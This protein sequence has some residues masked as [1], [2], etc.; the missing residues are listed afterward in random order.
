MSI[1]DGCPFYRFKSSIKEFGDPTSPIVLIGEAPGATEYQEGEVFV[2]QSGQLLRKFLER[3]GLLDKVYITNAVKCWPGPGNPSPPRDVVRRCRQLLEK[4]IR[5]F[6][7]KLLVPMGN[8]ALYALTSREGITAK[9]GSFYDSEEFECKVFP[10]FHPAALLRRPELTRLFE[11]DLSRIACFVQNNYEVPPPPT[12]AHVVETVDQALDLFEK[13]KRAPVF[14][15]DTET[16]STDPFDAA[17]LCI[18]FSFQEGEGWILP[19][20][21]EGEFFFWSQKE[22]SVLLPELRSV[23]GSLNLKIAHNSKFDREVLKL[24]LGVDVSPP[25]FDTML[26]SHLVDE[27]TP[28]DLK[29]LATLI[30]PALAG[31][32]E[33]LRRAYDVLDF[34]K[35]EKHYGLI[36]PEILYQYSAC[37]ADV[38]LR[39]YRML[40]EKLH[41]EELDDLFWMITMP[42]SEVLL[43]MELRGV[44][45]D[46]ARLVEMRKQFKKDLEKISDDIEAIASKYRRRYFEAKLQHWK[47]FLSSLL[48]NA[49][50]Q[51]ARPNPAVVLPRA[52]EA[53]KAL[54]ALRDRSVPSLDDDKI[55]ANLERLEELLGDEEPFDFNPQ[56]TK[57]LRE[58]LFEWIGLQPVKKTKGGA[59]STDEESLRL[60]LKKAAAA[61]V[62]RLLELLLEYREKSK[63]FSTYIEGLL[64]RARTEGGLNVIH[65]DY[66]IH[67]TACVTPET[68][69]LTSDGFRLVSE[70]V[71]ID[72]LPEG[73]TPF[74]VEVESLLGKEKTSHVFKACD[75]EVIR[76]TTTEGFELECTREHPVWA[77]KNGRE[78]FVRAEDL[79]EGDFVALKIGAANCGSFSPLPPD[80]MRLL[81]AAY[82]HCKRREGAALTLSEDALAVLEGLEKDE[83][84][85]TVV[86]PPDVLKGLDLSPV[87][88]FHDLRRCSRE[89]LFN[90]LLGALPGDPPWE[91]DLFSA[92]QIQLL[93]AN[94]GFLLLLEPC[95]DRARLHV[96]PGFAPLFNDGFRKQRMLR[97]DFKVFTPLKRVEQLGKRP[98]VI[99]FTVPESHS[100]VS[101]LFISHNTGRLASRNPNLQNIPRQTEIRSLFV[102]RPGHSFVSAD[103]GQI[104]VR[105]WGFN[106]Q[107]PDLLNVF[108]RGR[109]IHTEL[110]C[111]IFGVKPEEVTKELRVQTKTVVF[112]I[113][114][115]RGPYSIADQLGITPEEAQ[116]I[117]DKLFRRFPKA[118]EW[119]DRVISEALENG[120]V[121]TSLGRK[122]RFPHAKS[123]EKAVV[124]AVK[125]AAVNFPCQSLAA[126]LTNYALIRIYRRLKLE[127]LKACPVMQVHDQIVVEAPNDE[128]ERVRQIMEE[129]MLKRQPWF[130]VP[131]V[132]DIEI[133]E[134]A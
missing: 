58:L 94:L 14:S 42:L 6:P 65:T 55:M 19:L 85:S 96:A 111:E 80:L 75:R 114:Y 30:D 119:R 11:R 34:R 9:R 40:S 39:A 59:Y 109:D 118:A 104:E 122:R 133:K 66:L 31:Y 4:E 35:D 47:E 130:D 28:N 95:G 48:E 77:I 15:F 17:I 71:D 22:W 87:L 127:G 117:I 26:A 46:V 124:E 86:A 44:V 7:R 20:W 131:L 12:I 70:L 23:F 120:V 27:N 110:T 67:G 102:P 112:G 134:A 93:M 18:S 2:G 54:S 74:E 73:F 61:D 108:E 29:F 113:I 72:S 50:L 24:T 76:L 51:G 60:L 68:L 128:V 37:D 16:T 115:G 79:C 53:L 83:G 13:L 132:V 36:D 92:K 52:R 41:E 89:A 63:L 25:I 57:Q 100:F 3:F 98:V 123:S 90:F 1:C 5:A 125:R 129:E 10:T 97:F 21:Q 107:D 84:S 106:S 81:G 43:H 64:K 82:F 116:E 33:E 88:L 105:A 32:E 101:N 69:I 78:G 103:F 62:K 38:T 49:R 91:F 121:K 99:D 8:T 126:D 56:S 45:L